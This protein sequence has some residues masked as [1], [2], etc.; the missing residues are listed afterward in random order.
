MVYVHIYFCCGF[1]THKPQDSTVVLKLGT[2]TLPDTQ[3]QPEP[4]S[5]RAIEL[6]EAVRRW[7]SLAGREGWRRAYACACVFDVMWQV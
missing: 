4:P 1:S 2:E 5:L 6:R 7:S 3:E